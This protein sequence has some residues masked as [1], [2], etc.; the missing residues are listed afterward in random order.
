MTSKVEPFHVEPC[1]PAT[2]SCNL[3]CAQ[4]SASVDHSILVL[5]GHISAVRRRCMQ[6]YSD[7]VVAETLN[8]HW[9]HTEGCCNN[10]NGMSLLNWSFFQS[11]VCHIDWIQLIA[12]ILANFVHMVI[13]TTGWIKQD[14]KV[15][16]WSHTWWNGWITNIDDNVF[17]VVGSL[18]GGNSNKFCLVII[19]F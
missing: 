5:Y 16:G 6:H 10:P 18:T 2:G 17:L 8:I 14:T 13:E 4:L 1:R 11:W 9:C 3:F 12:H 15:P 7:S 19:W